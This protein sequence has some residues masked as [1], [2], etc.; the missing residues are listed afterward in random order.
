[1]CGGQAKKSVE[2]LLV[3]LSHSGKNWETDQLGKSVPKVAHLRPLP[4][5]DQKSQTASS[6]FNTRYVPRENHNAALDTAWPGGYSPEDTSTCHVDDGSQLTALLCDCGREK[7][8][9]RNSHRS[10]EEHAELKIISTPDAIVCPVYLGAP[11]LPGQ[12]L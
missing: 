6:P 2:G 5:P 1:M 12:C 11:S 4:S 7:H 8:Q 3:I 10:L 9:R